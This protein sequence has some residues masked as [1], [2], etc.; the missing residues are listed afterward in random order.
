MCLESYPGGPLS[1]LLAAAD[2]SDS[3]Q[4]TIDSTKSATV[5]ALT[6]TKPVW[7]NLIFKEVYQKEEAA[8]TPGH[9]PPVSIPAFRFTEPVAMPFGR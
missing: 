4:F 5:R 8:A 9:L 3:R 1:G 2:V 6:S 7:C